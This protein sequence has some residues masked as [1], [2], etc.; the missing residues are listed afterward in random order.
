M[1]SAKYRQVSMQSRL[2]CQGDSARA[3]CSVGGEGPSLFQL[4][5]REGECSGRKTSAETFF[6]LS[7]VAGRE[8]YNLGQLELFK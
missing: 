3:G 7:Q 8:R 6:I 1:R 4:E 5:Q 2:H